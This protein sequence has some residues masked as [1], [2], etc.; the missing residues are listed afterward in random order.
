MILFFIAVNTMLHRKLIRQVFPLHERDQLKRLGDE[1]YNKPFKLQ[2]I[3]KKYKKMC[4][5]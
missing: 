1:W 4:V 2:P 5:Y 3:G